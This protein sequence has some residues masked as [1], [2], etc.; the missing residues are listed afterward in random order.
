MRNGIELLSCIRNSLQKEKQGWLWNET[1]YLK[2]IPSRAFCEQIQE[3]GCCH[4]SGRQIALKK[5]VNLVVHSVPTPYCENQLL[6][7]KWISQ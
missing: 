3:H 2:V 7:E 4:N 6:E 1:Q 5:I